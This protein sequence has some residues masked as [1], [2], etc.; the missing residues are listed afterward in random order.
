MFQFRPISLC[1]VAYKAI[2]KIIVHRLKLF[3]PAWVSESQTSFVSG[4][5]IT[6]NII[7]AQEII[8][9]VWHKKGKKGW[10]TIKVDLEK[11][12][13]QLEW[14]FIDD[15]L[16]DI[17]IPNTL[18]ALK[19][20]MCPLCRVRFCG[21][22]L[23]HLLLFCVEKVSAAK[24]TIF[25]SP[26][27]SLDLKDD[28]CKP[29]TYGGLGFWKLDIHNEAFFMKNRV[30]NGGEEGGLHLLPM[31]VLLRIAALKEPSHLFSEDTVGWSLHFITFW[32]KPVELGSDVCCDNLETLCQR[33]VIV[34]GNMVEEMV[35]DFKSKQVAGGNHKCS[36][37]WQAFFKAAW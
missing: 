7:I 36:S 8:H 15:T 12:Y 29:L 6:Y 31:S 30:S 34:F 3:L 17:G 13:D 25:F 24:T 32:L 18:Q 37:Y 11:A 20:I 26:N 33:N 1:N 5:S 27:V 9:S 14:S 35:V 16:A 23:R 19:C 28:V 10:M 22:V 21:M 2:T 4:R